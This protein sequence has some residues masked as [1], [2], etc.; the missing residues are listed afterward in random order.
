MEGEETPPG[1]ASGLHQSV[2]PSSPRPSSQGPSLDAPQHT[3][4]GPK[5]SG[6]PRGE[7]VSE[8]DL[9]DKLREYVEEKGGT[10]KPGW[11]IEKRTRFSGNTA[12][13]SD[14]YYFS[15]E[16]RKFRSRQEVVRAMGLEPDAKAKPAKPSRPEILDAVRAA[17]PD[18]LSQ[19]PLHLDNGITV[20]ICYLRT[21]HN[22]HGSARG[23]SSL[24]QFA[25]PS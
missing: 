3:S 15:P 11:R 12:G 14:A 9:L 19:L 7:K 24:P 25:V 17:E 5:S 20:A 6:G 22:E 18:P 13:T 23:T 21:L 10:W 4:P 8:A 2:A 16:N 1:P